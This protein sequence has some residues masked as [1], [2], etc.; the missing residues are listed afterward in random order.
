MKIILLIE[1]IRYFGNSGESKEFERVEWVKFC[2]SK[3]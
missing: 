2:F 3:I 1:S